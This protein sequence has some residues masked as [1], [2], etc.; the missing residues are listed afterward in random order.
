MSESQYTNMAIE[1][2]LAPISED[3]KDACTIHLLQYKG[4]SPLRGQN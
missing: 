4:M 3:I 1:E 2:V